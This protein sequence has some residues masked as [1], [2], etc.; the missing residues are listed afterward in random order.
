MELISHKNYYY[1][2]STNH[3]QKIFV[4]NRDE[5]R[6]FFREGKKL[7]KTRE[8]FKQ[9]RENLSAEPIQI[10]SQLFV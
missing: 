2:F 6:E 8:R 10:T 1:Y 3:F 5:E 7:R 4:K 9:V